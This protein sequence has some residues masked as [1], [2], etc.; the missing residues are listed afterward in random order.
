M[1]KM[2]QYGCFRARWATTNELRY[3]R[4][5]KVKKLRGLARVY[6]KSLLHVRSRRSQHL[7]HKTTLDW[8]LALKSK[9]RPQYNFSKWLTRRKAFLRARLEG[10]WK[11]LQAL[12]LQHASFPF[13]LLHWLRRAA[14]ATFLRYVFS[15]ILFEVSVLVAQLELQF[16]TSSSRSYLVDI[17]SLF[18]TT[19]RSTADINHGM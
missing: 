14:A 8:N 1:L 5:G 2:K 11:K 6:L 16:Q 17:G 15:R 19:A 3:R 10:L 4:V 7:A 12:P 13:F 18:S 9:C